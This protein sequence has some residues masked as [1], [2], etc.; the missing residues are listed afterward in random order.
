MLTKAVTLPAADLSKAT[1]MVL[2]L[3]ADHFDFL[4]LGVRDETGNESKL[5]VPVG[6]GWNG[7]IISVSE[8][9]RV[10]M[11]AI[12]YLIVAHSSA[13]SVEPNNRFWVALLD[14]R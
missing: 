7:Y 12:T 6:S 4:E 13:V 5:K 2:L 11:E 10:N 1:E 14:F 9:K 8:F 3:K